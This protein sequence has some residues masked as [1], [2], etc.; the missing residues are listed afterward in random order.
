MRDLHTARLDLVAA[1]MAHHDAELQS[2]QR[3]GLLLRAEVPV[4]WPPGEYD[5]PALEFFRARL[6]E[7]PEAIG[8][9]GWYAVRRGTRGEPE[10]VV[11]AGGYFGPPGPEGF[12]EI[13][14]SVVE[15]FRRQGYAKEMVGAL[16]EHAFATPGVVRVI[17]E[18][19]LPNVGSV[20]VLE[21]CGFVAAGAGREPDSVRFACDNPPRRESLSA[22]S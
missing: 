8:W 21:R 16:L 6:Q 14:Y 19:T 1:T 4:G 13:G 10:V 15:S 17:A 22:G 5:R 9:Y 2:P 20:R 7:S 12:V 11:G 3:L 18:T